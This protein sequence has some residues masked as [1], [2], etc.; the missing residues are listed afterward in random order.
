MDEQ[1][2]NELVNREEQIAR[3]IEE[4]VR[5]FPDIEVQ[6][7]ITKIVEQ[8]T[9]P[10]GLKKFVGLMFKPNHLKRTDGIPAKM[11]DDTIAMYEKAR[12]NAKT[13]QEYK[14][15]DAMMERGESLSDL[16]PNLYERLCA[17]PESMYNW[18]PQLKTSLKS[19]GFFK[20]PATKVWRLPIELAQYIRIEYQD[21]NEESRK[22]FNRIVFDA[23]DL[24]EN[25]TYFIKTGVFSSKFEF[26]NTHCTEPLEMGDYFSVINNFA[27]LV[28]AGRSVDLVVREWI[29]DVENRPTIYN[30]MPLHTEFRAFVDLDKDEL[31]DVVPY[32]N[33]VVMTKV[34][35]QQA[36]K[37]PSILEDYETYQSIK[38]VLIDDYNE[39]LGTVKTHLK[40]IIPNIDLKGKWSLDIMK[41]G[42]DFY[43]IDMARMEKSALTDLIGKE[44]EM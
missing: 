16:T 42:K 21:T 39:N 27:M 24:D 43:V 19:D 22:E 32:W 35:Q 18:L 13:E 38:N 31:I 5:Y 6:R 26:R 34:L 23:F 11:I 15:N 25:K 4:N 8:H 41:N 17:N 12:D 28:G 33:A 3:A 44:I 1:E 29:D 30:G 36:Q 14:Y 37:N 20:M 10:N 40:K 9:K 2:K 7:A